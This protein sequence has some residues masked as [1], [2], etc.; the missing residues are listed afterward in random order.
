MTLEDRKYSLVMG[1]DVHR[2]GRFLELD[3]ATAGRRETLAEWFYSYADGSM[4]LE[5]YEGNIPSPRSGVV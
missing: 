1:S 5:Q 3:D 2:D 4:G